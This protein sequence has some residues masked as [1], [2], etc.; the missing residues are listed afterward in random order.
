MKALH[1]IR[2]CLSLAAGV[3]LLGAGANS[4]AQTLT[5]SWTN[6]FDTGASTAGYAWW[7]DMYQSAYGF[8]YQ[9]P[10]TNS[11][12]TTLNSTLAPPPVGGAGSGSLAFWSLWPGVPAN[13]GKG[14]QN[15]IIGFFGGGNPFDFS[16]TI[17]ATKYDSLSFDLYVD[18]SSPLDRASNVC[19]LTVGFVVNNYSTYTITNVV[20]GTNNFGKW[21]R[22]VCPI[23]KTTAPAPPSPLA[24]GPMFNINCYGG[25]NVSLFTNTIPTKMWID[26]LYLKLST[27]VS[28]PPAM[29]RT[30]GTPKAGLNLLS[31]GP[32][33]DQYQRNSIKLKQTTGVGWV[34]QQG[35]SYSMTITNFPDGTAQPGYQAHLFITTG[36][37]NAA[38]LDYNETNVVWLNVQANSNNTGVAAFRYKINEPGA[39]SNMFGA[40]Y[41]G[42][43]SAGT[44]TN[45]AAPT[46]LGTWGLTFNNDTNITITGPGGASVTFNIRPEVA[47][48]F[49]EPLNVVFGAQPN[50]PFNVGQEVVLSSVSGTNSGAAFPIVSDN[51]LADSTLDTSIWSILTGEPNTIFVFPLDPGQKVISWR[52]PDSGFGLQ[53]SKNLSSSNNWIVLTGS[54]APGAPLT[55]WTI[56]GQRYALVPSADLAPDQNYFRMF[57]RRF[58]KLQLLMPGETAAPGTASGKTGTPDAQVAGLPFNVTVNAVDANWFPATYATDHIIH[59]TSSDPVATLPADT[60]LVGGKATLSVTVFTSGT[61]TVTAS[62]VTDPTKTANTGTPI[63]IP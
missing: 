59:I 53:V 16:Q 20:I 56:S 7:Y 3:A 63:M 38:S 21:L 24:A 13:S 41:I 30:F 4:Q 29:A 48:P 49:V 60:T 42:I 33:S 5:T 2:L 26:N 57:T 28:P 18:P 54:E 50:N 46:V 10:I 6:T 27:V 1:L 17:D 11:F 32:S 9:T 45:L 34:G 12:E 35:V 55:T 25:E 39:N 22:Y 23:D 37:G 62:D 40:E 52:I 43:A 15:L 14:G 19:S 44:L 8:G 31:G 51:F 58:T 61:V 47:A 36:P